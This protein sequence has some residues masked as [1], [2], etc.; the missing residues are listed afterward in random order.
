[1]AEQKACNL[2]T[3][4]TI[5]SDDYL[6]AITDVV[7]ENNVVEKISKADF[8]DDI[9]SSD[10]SNLLSVGTDDNLKATLPTTAVT[11]GSY[12]NTNLTV[13]AYGR[14]TAAANG[15][16]GGGGLA[17]DELGTITTN[18]TLTTMT[19]HTAYVNGTVAL[20][21]PTTLTANMENVVVFDFTTTSTSQPTI[22]SSRDLT[23]TCAVTN[24]NATVTGTKTLFLTE[25]EVGSKVTIATVD[26]QVLS[27]ASDTSLELTTSYAGTTASGLT[28]GHKFVKW[29]D[30]NGGKAPTAYSIISGVRNILTFKTHDG[31][32]TWEA[33]YSTFGASAVPYTFPNLS[34]NG[35]LGG[36]SE[37]VSSDSELNSSYAA[38]KV[39]DGSNSTEWRP[40]GSSQ[41]GHYFTWYSNNPYLVT[42]YNFY[43]GFSDGGGTYVP[44]AGTFYYSDDG[45]NWVLEKTFTNAVTSFGSSWSIAVDSSS[46]GYHKYR[47]LV[48]TATSNES[49]PI[50]TEARP[51]GYKI[52]V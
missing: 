8:I 31:G 6:M 21:L 51:V 3:V 17:I 35:T 41:S 43:N 32:A 22:T 24:G 16:G 26:Y 47:K 39:V 29:S 25:L 23:G 1:M 15:S 40:T 48:I 5:A 13:D 28:V 46:Q 19:A 30:K 2:S 14:I 7:P 38:W 34:E 52:E 33:E 18:Q 9:I 45:T 20:T 44:T 12:T 4:T 11:A 10:S 50:L 42:Q 49:Q 27:I 36:A 37:A